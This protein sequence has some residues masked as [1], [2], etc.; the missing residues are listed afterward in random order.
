MFTVRTGA[1][2]Q[3][4]IH[5]YNLSVPW[6][7]STATQ[8][9]SFDTPGETSP[10]S[11]QFTEDGKTL[12][13]SGESYQRIIQFKLD[14][15]WDL[16]S[17]RPLN[18]SSHPVFDITLYPENVISND[19]DIFY[20]HYISPD[21]S[22]LY[23]ISQYE[24]TMLSNRV[25]QLELETPYDITTAK[26]NNRGFLSGYAFDTIYY[27]FADV[28]G[29][30]FNGTGSHLYL[31]DSA[32]DRINEFALTTPYKLDTAV[33]TNRY[34]NIAKE[35][36][37]GE[38]TPQG[39]VL[40]KDGTKL[41]FSGT[42]R[43]VVWE[44]D[45]PSQDI[46][47]TGNTIVHGDLEVQYKLD[48]V[49]FE[50]DRAS[51]TQSISI[52][53]S[54]RREYDTPL[55]VYGK[56]DIRKIGNDTNFTEFTRNYD[57]L[58]IRGNG[59]PFGIHFN[60]SGT[61]MFVLGSLPEELIEYSL[62][63][64]WDIKTA[65]LVQEV[66]TSPVL[67][68]HELF[69]K[70]DG[71][72]FYIMDINPDK[73][74]QFTA[75]TPW[76]IST[77]GFTTEYQTTE[78]TG[79]SGLYIGTGGTT[80]Y[81]TGY[82]NDRIYQYSLSVAWDVSSAGFT[83]QFAIGSG[84]TTP[85]NTQ[86]E[87]IWVTPDETKVYTTSV[88]QDTIYEYTLST[89]GDVSTASL[90]TSFPL[91]NQGS[92]YGL[93]FNPNGKEFYI[94]ENT[95]DSIF[96]YTLTTP[97]D[98][99]TIQYPEG[100][101]SI[102]YDGNEDPY[103][104]YI[105]PDGKKLY[106]VEYNDASQDLF[107][108]DL[109][110]PWKLNTATLKGIRNYSENYLD[111]F[112]KP[113][114]TKMYMTNYDAAATSSIHEYT[115]TTPWDSS[116]AGLTTS[117]VTGGDDAYPY[118]ITF[119]P[120]GTRFWVCGDQ[121]DYIYPY[122]MTTPWDLTTARKVSEDF[123]VGN[124]ETAPTS[125]AFD[126]T[127]N[128]L[129]ILGDTGNDITQ[130]DIEYGYEYD[131]RYA[132]Y[133][134]ITTNLGALDTKPEGLTFKPDGTKLWMAG[135]S[136]NR[137]YEY[138][139]STPWNVGTAGFTTSLLV[140]SR[141]TAPLE[142]RFSD[143]GYNAYV[144]D[145]QNYGILQYSLATAWDISSAINVY[146]NFYYATLIYNGAIGV[147]GFEFGKNGTRLYLSNGSG[148][149][150]GLNGAYRTYQFNLS[151]P[152]NIE[153]AELI[154]SYKHHNSTNRTEYAPRGIV[155]KPDGTQFSVVGQNYDRVV[156][157][158][159]K[160]PWEI[161]TAYYDGVWIPNDTY[162]I[163]G[164]LYGSQTLYFDF[165]S[166]G[167]KAYLASN[168]ADRIY[169]WNLT[170]PYRFYSAIPNYNYSYF[171][172]ATT[173]DN[174]TVPVGIRISPDD[175]KFF[176]TNNVSNDDRIYEYKLPK[177]SIQILG[178]TE[179]KSLSANA[180]SIQNLHTD[181]L[182]SDNIGIEGDLVV[183][184]ASAEYETTIQFETPTADRNVIIPDKS[185][186][187]GIVPGGSNL[188]MYNDGSRLAAGSSFTYD[189]NYGSVVLTGGNITTTTPYPV[190]NL[191]QTWNNASGIYTGVQLNITNT[192]SDASSK[193]VDLRVNNTTIFDVYR[194]GAVTLNA[195]Y[196]V[197]G[198]PTGTVGQ[199]ARVTDANSPTLGA[200]VVGSGTS[201]ALCWY[202]GNNWSVIGV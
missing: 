88:A 198:L 58:Y 80:M 48:T 138:T 52:G 130:Y 68:G 78:D 142:I 94:G 60:P 27:L 90:T 135:D 9:I 195:G 37:G 136:T 111:V 15:A 85:A 128:K 171:L 193:L 35:Y 154:T 109:A 11:I 110:T 28:Q 177:E 114:G 123:F 25:W 36:F 55:T 74:I 24:Y 93:T 16:S 162:N 168:G 149:A 187:V 97:Y 49:D 163:T 29:L 147:T 81:T 197:S 76:D 64:P 99:T 6:D 70:P 144:L 17:V 71:T 124:E 56:A 77:I 118:G 47:I 113:D 189:P 120:D 2:N 104:F 143:D 121:N 5:E 117:F 86:P 3:G 65:T 34:I 102:G 191:S 84:A 184:D 146:R 196:T 137:I 176:I 83:T 161:E 95:N 181:T 150:G 10:N 179:V 89:P 126:S 165:N 105:R 79:M 67:N 108:Y 51:I 141:T 61:R 96:K 167:T 21:G 63:T 182:S 158:K 145:A 50:A 46:E 153:T 32:R 133:S 1:S 172:G 131:V 23:F 98:L 19:L 122:E 180:A 53:S 151:E 183:G 173:G 156:T 87:G 12:Y 100:I 166:D 91:Q 62:S 175:E 186:F 202:N 107:E 152:W 164:T 194:T 188:I 185:G 155:F 31:L 174:I 13:V 101:L 192:N 132:S 134:G 20:S 8:T 33:A 201:N 103:G 18:T 43:N 178:K 41:Y 115:L 54:D 45:I 119:E 69:I 73:V 75:T 112:F 199:I 140:S 148:T 170:V 169:E 129:Y 57:A 139:M 116:T 190:L 66:S 106:S 38:A 72:E 160:T 59:E 14:V 39:L 44:L 127:G 200:T 159:L 125:L 30:A 42:T 157:H 82:T 4:Q 26:M 92:S 40:K 7:V 22:K